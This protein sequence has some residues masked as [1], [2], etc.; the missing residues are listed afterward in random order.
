MLVVPIVCKFLVAFL[1][2]SFPSFVVLI[3]GT[4]ILAL[5]LNGT[6]AISSLSYI[7]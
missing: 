6:R 4:A 7:N 1:T 3:R 5:V 2:A